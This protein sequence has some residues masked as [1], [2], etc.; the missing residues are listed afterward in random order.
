MHMHSTVSIHF[1]SL[2]WM[3]RNKCMWCNRMA[4]PFTHAHMRRWH[5]GIKGNKLAFNLNIIIIN[6][7]FLLRRCR[8]R[9]RFHWNR[10]IRKSLRRYRGM[11]LCVFICHKN[12]MGLGRVWCVCQNTF[13]HHHQHQRRTLLIWW[14]YCAIPSWPDCGLMGQ[15]MRTTTMVQNRTPRK[16]S[17]INFYWTTFSFH[18]CIMRAELEQSLGRR[19]VACNSWPGGMETANGVCVCGCVCVRKRTNRTAR[20]QLES[21][22]V[23]GTSDAECETF[24]WII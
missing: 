23:L 4:Q 13:H 10:I 8:R 6:F 24:Q 7:L 3:G 17:A 9:R 11:I 14:N 21:A 22:M 5:R 16:Q 15:A 2:R 1:S 20:P 19:V 12:S 18:S